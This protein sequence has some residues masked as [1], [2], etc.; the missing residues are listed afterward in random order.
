MFRHKLNKWL[1]AWLVCWL[2]LSGALASTMPIYALAKSDAMSAMAEV[3][4]PVDDVI[5]TMP[6][7]R[8]NAN[9]DTSDLPC[10][11]CV[12]CH[13]AASVVPP[14]MPVIIATAHHD[15]PQSVAAVQFVSFIPELRPRP[16]SSARA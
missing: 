9:E 8:V 6:C 13:I 2:P 16:P 7:H 1:I 12:L 10:H 14:T 5:A 15:C 4:S 11:H 3:A